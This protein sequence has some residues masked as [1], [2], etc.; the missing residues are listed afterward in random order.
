MKTV[1]KGYGKTK[2]RGG[3]EG[4]RNRRR[5]WENT[6]QGETKRR[7]QL[8]EILWE[9]LKK[10]RNGGGKKGEKATDLNPRE[11]GI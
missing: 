1:N 4:R 10:Q 2:K 9:K 3:G 11:T 7:E 5:D 8:S 6:N